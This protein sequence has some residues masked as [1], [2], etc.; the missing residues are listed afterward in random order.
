MTKTLAPF[1]IAFSLL[2]LVVGFL[3]WRERQAIRRRL[4]VVCRQPIADSV[5]YRRLRDKLR[6][7]VS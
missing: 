1:I 6:R 5:E 4:Y 3:A 2:W 7:R